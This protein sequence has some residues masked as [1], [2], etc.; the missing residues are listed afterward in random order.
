MDKTLASAFVAAAFIHPLAVFAQTA[1][2]KPEPD[3]TFAG[4]AGLFSDYRFRGYTQT[5]YKPAFQGGLDFAHK[6]GFYVGNWNSNVEQSLYTGASLEMDFYAGYKGAVGDVGYDVG[7]YYY[8][9]PGSGRNGQPRIDNGEIYIG[10]SYGPVAL[11]Y[12]YSATKFFSL[13]EG[14]SVDTRGSQYLDLAASQDL[15]GGWGINGH[16]GWQKVKNFKQLGAKDDTTTDYRLGVTRDISGWVLG[17][18]LIATSR[19]EFFTTGS[20]EDAGKTRLAASV[21]KTF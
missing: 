8:A 4:N 3:Y 2:A 7:Y 11:K 20:G 6:S 21:T 1:P 19:K 13:G 17:A 5:A 10:G 9:Y 16:I 14:T 15:G 12:Y 18:S